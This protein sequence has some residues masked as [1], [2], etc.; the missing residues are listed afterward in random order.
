MIELLGCMGC[1]RVLD[2]Y[3]FIARCKGCNSKFV[4]DIA[5]IFYNKFRWFLTNPR[6]VTK[7]YYQDFREKLRDK[8]SS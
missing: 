2:Q 7:L 1:W 4:K 8:S 3:T 5:P 6:H